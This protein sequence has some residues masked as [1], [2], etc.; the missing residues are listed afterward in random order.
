PEDVVPLV[1]ETALWLVDAQQA[2]VFH[3]DAERRELWSRSNGNEIRAPIGAGIVGAVA[4][5]G[6]PIFLADPFADTRFNATV[7]G[8]V[9]RKP[10]SLAAAPIRDGGGA[11][12]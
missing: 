2:V 11:I 5:H 12:V 7:D 9:V 6:E 3:V 1:V 10:R 8:C 4:K